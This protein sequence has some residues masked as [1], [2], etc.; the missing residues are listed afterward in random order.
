MFTYFIEKQVLILKFDNLI[1]AS[2]VTA[3][4]A[5]MAERT[6]PEPKKRD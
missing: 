3:Q 2:G 5:K 4:T 1:T 6:T